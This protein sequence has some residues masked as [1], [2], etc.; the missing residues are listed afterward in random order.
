[1]VL[2]VNPM[3]TPAS[4]PAGMPPTFFINSLNN[5]LGIA[6]S[7]ISY[8]GSHTSVG[9]EFSNIKIIVTYSLKCGCR[10]FFAE[11]WR[12]GRALQF[13]VN[14]QR[15]QPQTPQVTMKTKSLELN[16]DLNKEWQV[17]LTISPFCH[18]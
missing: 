6:Y 10:Q 17:T 11:A 12:G 13:G 14:P 8:S 4:R 3:G 16:E 15:Q 9:H 7:G 2:Q 18:P 5:Y 1:M